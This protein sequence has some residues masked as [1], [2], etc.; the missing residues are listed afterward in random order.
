MTSTPYPKKMMKSVKKVEETRSKRTDADLEKLKIGPEGREEILEGYHPDYKPK[1]FGEVR[2]G[3]NAGD[4]A[5]KEV[6]KILESHPAVDHD[7]IDLSEIDYDVDVLIIGGGGAGTAAAIWAHE[8]GVDPE[9]ILIATKLRH[10][11]AN[12]IM[13]QGGTQGVTAEY[14]GPAQHYLDTM[15]GGHFT[16]KPELVET[17]V[18]DAPKILDWHIDLGVIYDREEDGSL[19]VNPGGG[20]SRKRLHAAEDYT[21]LE[22]MRVVRDRARN[23]GIEVVEFAPAVELLTDGDGGVGGALLYNLE[24]GQYY[25]ARAKTTI[26]ATGGFGRLHI[27]DFPTT[28]HYGA[29]A[30]GLVMAYRTGAKLRDIDTVQYHPTGAAYPDQIVGLLVTEKVR[31]LGGQPVNAD[32]ELF[33]YPLEPRDVEAGRII[34]ECETGKGVETPIGVTGIWLDSP[35]ID[36]IKGEGTFEENF[37]SICR[38]YRRQGIDPTEVPIL[39]YPTLHYQNGGIEI[40]KWTKT[41]VKGLLVA[42]EASGGVHGKN[43][44]MG[45]STL[46]CYVFGRRAG[47]TGAKRAKKERKPKKLSLEHSK[48]YGEKMEELGVD[49]G[50]K[51]P[52]ILPDYRG[53]KPLS[54][55]LE[56]RL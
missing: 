7:E 45:N 31:S 34:K 27:Q 8:K 5:P 2:Y 15:G 52:V 21:G 46:G 11:D 39:V 13:A 29:T 3:P 37:P 41:N 48:K 6:V 30:D 32:G 28:N 42:G 9:K 49:R 1:A 20:A 17:L 36:E 51:S 53:E 22:Q 24:T 23:L 4:T 12:S 18:K 43:R 16:N 10:G 47:I 25:V 40:D 26:L 35:I 33:V 55:A 14:D 19:T 38:L 50:R 56:L 54:R 44:L